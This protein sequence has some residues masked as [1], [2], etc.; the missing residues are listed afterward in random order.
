MDGP[1]LSL[2]LVLAEK[3]RDAMIAEE[4]AHTATIAAHNRLMEAMRLPPR[5][6][7]P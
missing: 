1:S 4:R 7:E 5:K 3:Y 6:E 2:I